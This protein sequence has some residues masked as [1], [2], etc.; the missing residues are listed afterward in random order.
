[1][2]TGAPAE[3]RARDS[4]SS[5]RTCSGNCSPSNGRSARDVAGSV[6]GARPMPRSMRSGMQ[7]LERVEHLGHAQRRM[8]RQHDAARPDANP[9]VA[10]AMCSIRIS[11]AELAMLAMPWCS[12]NQ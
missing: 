7:R 8:V 3:T 12:A 9:R 6:P 4:A 10:D 11:G 1:M 2:R 5:S